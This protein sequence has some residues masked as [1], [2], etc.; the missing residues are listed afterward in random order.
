MLPGCHTDNGQ[1][2]RRPAKV[3][4]C[5]YELVEN[6]RWGLG[7]WFQLWGIN[8][9]ITCITAAKLQTLP[10][11]RL[12][13]DGTTDGNAKDKQQQKRQPPGSSHHL[14]D[15]L[16]RALLHSR[17]DLSLRLRGSHRPFLHPISSKRHVGRL[18]LRAGLHGEGS[19]VLVLFGWCIVEENI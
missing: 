13:S 2:H 5:M 8:I 15:N 14:V 10:T 9:N 18:R 7:G 12:R 17:Y 16:P 4:Y 19:L 1:H 11:A 3:T 6:R